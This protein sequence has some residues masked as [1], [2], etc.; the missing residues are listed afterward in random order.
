MET[1]PSNI[2]FN[3]ICQQMSKKFGKYTILKVSFKFQRQLM[4]ICLTQFCLVGLYVEMFF[5]FF[6][7]FCRNGLKLPTLIFYGLISNKPWLGCQT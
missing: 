6:F 4:C 5:F 2:R 3:K 7:F 1:S